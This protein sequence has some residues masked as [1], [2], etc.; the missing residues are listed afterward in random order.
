MENKIAKIKNQLDRGVE[1]AL[2]IFAS[3]MVIVV[4]AQVLSR[5]V[6]KV[7]LAWTEEASRFLF[8]WTIFL[9]SAI[10]IKRKAHLGIELLIEKLPEKLGI[11]VSRFIGI[12]V[13]SFLVLVIY[14]SFFVI[15]LTIY[16]ASPS[17]NIPMALVYA[18]VPIGCFLMAVNVIEILLKD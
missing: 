5:Y 1:I 3:V 8:A 7:P 6:A 12:V 2:A 14:Q 13:I 17:L 18:S 15:R 16:Q 10:G 9:G 11:Y 4:F